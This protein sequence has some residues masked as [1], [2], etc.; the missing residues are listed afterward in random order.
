[1][2]SCFFAC[3]A[4]SFPAEI[5]L[6][7]PPTTQHTQGGAKTDTTPLK[8]KAA[9][10]EKAGEGEEQANSGKVTLCVHMKYMLVSQSSVCFVT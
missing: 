7:L 1:M 9:A 8:A 5:V 3:F 10:T 6:A 2:L 4:A